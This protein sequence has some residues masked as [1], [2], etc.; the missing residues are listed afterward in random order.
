MNIGEC[1]TKLQSGREFATDRQTGQ[2]LYSP[3]Q[4]LT[5]HTNKGKL[6]SKFRLS[7]IRKWVRGMTPTF[8]GGYNVCSIMALNHSIDCDSGGFFAQIL[9]ANC[10]ELGN[11]S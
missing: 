11:F 4:R 3:N 8:F 7:R 1:M 10:Q 9:I 2:K 5:G 6:F